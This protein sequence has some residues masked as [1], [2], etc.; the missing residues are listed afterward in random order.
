MHLLNFKG[1]SNQELIHL[2]DL[3]IAIK[4]CPQKYAK[5]LEGKTAALVFQKT[6]TRTRVSFEV[7]MTQLGGHGL[8][9]DWRATNFT[10]ADLS[11]EIGYLSRNID[12]IMARLLYNSDLNRIAK[13][14]LVPVINGCDEKYHP[15]QAIADLITI[16]EKKGTLSGAKLVYVGV[17][18]NVANSL[19][20]ACTKT[21]VKIT[22]VC[23]I[24]NEASRDNE[25]LKEAEKTGLWESTLDLQ[26]A[27][28][29]AD[30]IYTDT[31]VDM[32]FFTDSNYAEEKEKRTKLM[33]PYQIN[34]NLLKD[35]KAYVMHDM[36][37]HRG[38]EITAD[39]IE[40]PKSIIYEQAENR[41]YSAKAILLKL[42]GV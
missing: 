25:L 1:L 23:P 16:K 38:Y 40:N 26:R 24:F 14:S 7:A 10:V 19:I 29:D 39:V 9:L 42:I 30:F 3:A 12:C 21:G 18:N 28:S 17:H 11:D 41:L 36:P 2:V 34:I 35:T 20:E 4:N 32:E 13:T 33:M 31:W 22:T 8:F 5:T 6:S 15:S 27:V 37:I